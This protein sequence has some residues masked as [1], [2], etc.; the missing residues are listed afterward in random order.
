M[1]FNRMIVYRQFLLQNLF[2]AKFDLQY[3]TSKTRKNNITGR[4]S[5]LR[6]SK[7]SV[8]QINTLAVHNY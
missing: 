4:Q 2:D 5:N 1:I 3:H 6:F 7:K 8:G